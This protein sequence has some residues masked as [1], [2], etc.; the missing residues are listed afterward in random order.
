M[1]H[2]NNLRYAND[3]VGL[4]KNIWELRRMLRDLQYEKQKAR[5]SRR[6]RLAGMAFDKL[7]S[8]LGSHKF[9]KPQSARVH[10]MHLTSTII[11]NGDNE[12]H[13]AQH[14]YNEKSSNSNRKKNI[15]GKVKDKTSLKHIGCQTEVE[16]WLKTYQNRSGPELRMYL[17]KQMIG[18]S[19][20]F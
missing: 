17:G 1:E 9:I 4:T 7:F 20:S 10:D 11:R 15:E 14:F 18:G 3:V 19:G 12:I 13:K 5:I 8:T 16:T 6:I 2:T